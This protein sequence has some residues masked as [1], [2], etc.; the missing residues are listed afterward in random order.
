MPSFDERSIAEPIDQSL[1][2]SFDP[3]GRTA[4][5]ATRL[6]GLLAALEFLPKGGL[7][8][9]VIET[10]DR[11][12]AF[13]LRVQIHDGIYAGGVTGAY[14]SGSFG[15]TEI[16]YRFCPTRPICLVAIQAAN[17]IRRSC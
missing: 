14:L 16:L 12:I 13:L 17:S 15:S 5:T 4:P 3:V 10:I 11:G 6:E 1:D 2:G 8:A 7:R 9:Q